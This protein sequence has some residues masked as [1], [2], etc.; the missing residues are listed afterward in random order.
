MSFRQNRISA[1]LSSC[2]LVTAMMWGVSS[3]VLAAADIKVTHNSGETQVAANPQN[4]VVLDWS[5][6]DT[7]AQLGV[8]VSGIP[9][10]NPPEM[11]KQYRE[12]DF[13]RAGTLFEPDFEALKN[14]NPDLIILGRRAQGKFDE[15]SKF[16]TTI[17]LTPDPTDLLGSVERNTL[18]LGEIFGKQDKAAELTAKLKT[19]VAELRKLT[20]KRG[21]GLLVLTT[22][23]RMAAFGPGTRF[24]LIH[25]VFGVE[26]AVKD[27][28]VGRHGQAVSFE[29][30]LEADPDWL[31][32]MDRDAAIGRE[33]TAAAEMMDNELVEA[34]TAGSKDQIVYLDPASWYLLDNSGI[35][36]MQDSVDELIKVFSA[37]R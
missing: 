5:T 20:A 17:D 33:G 21:D 30:L 15:V 34:T 26:E 23:G 6:L 37:A 36:V 7:L 12:G 27:L 31:F 10:T 19:S 9:S 1:G 14:A 32:V 13:V 3:P 25:D 11:L 22:G 28:K 35:G 18:M 29:F 8:Q 16:G 4:V 2:L 24:G